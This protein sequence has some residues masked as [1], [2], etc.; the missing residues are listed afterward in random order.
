ME[1]PHTGQLPG[2]LRAAARAIAERL[3]AAGQRGWM[4]GGVVRD[5][6]VGRVPVDVDM[7]SAARPEVVERLFEH[8]LAVGRAFG[9]VSVR[10]GSVDIELATF[11]S[12]SGYA[13]ARRPDQVLYGSSVEED[14]RRRDFTCNALFLDPLTDELADPTGGLADLDARVLRT[15]GD[16][17]ERFAEDG[18]RLL[19]MARFEAALDLAPAEGLHAAARGAVA[20]LAG[21]SAERVLEE[22]TRIF[23]GPCCARAVAVLGE[24]GL[25][26]RL[27]PLRAAALGGADPRHAERLAA[28]EHLPAPPGVAL[29][30]AVLL[31]LEDDGRALEQADALRVSRDLR[32]ALAE[33]WDRLRRVRALDGDPVARARALR[34]AAG[35]QALV[36]ARAW[37]AARGEP[38]APLAALAAWRARARDAELEPPRLLDGDDL[39]ALGV[40]RGPRIGALLAEL[41]AEQ[42]RGRVRSRAE[43]ERFLR[44]SGLL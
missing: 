10:L 18:L 38:D 13:D 22:L 14:A 31:E 17:A 19:R 24:C 6:A 42:L 11:R 12:E 39:Q 37:A 44:E 16:A 20:A 26:E 34:G 2:P 27:L 8:T 21:V 9:V 1:R 3:R 40:E 15:V 36:L 28:L 29:A 7:V 4:V 35:P 33:L 41:E 32:R 23:D 5:L 43:A 30:L 25:L